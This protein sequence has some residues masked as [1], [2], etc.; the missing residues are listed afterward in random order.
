K[1]SS[2]TIVQLKMELQNMKK[3]LLISVESGILKLQENIKELESEIRQEEQKV[4]QLPSEQREFFT[5]QRENKLLD[6]IYIYL[7]NKRSEASIAKASSVAKAQILD[8]ATK[9]R[10]KYL[11]PQSFSIYLFAILMGL[12]IP[13]ALTLLLY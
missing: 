12:G 4:Y 2:P 9:Y 10:V 8:H 3:Q 7:V 1:L 5:L 6:E 13:I 11:G